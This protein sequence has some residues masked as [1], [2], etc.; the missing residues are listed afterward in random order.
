MTPRLKTTRAARELIKAYEPFHGEAVRRGRR[1]V[2]G[3]GHTAAAK[4]GATVSLQDAELLLIYDVM[5]A[6]QAVHAALGEDLPKPMR[7][8]LV[9][10]A[11]S[12]GVNAFRV[13]DVARLARAGR[14]ED[15]A[16]ALESWV[17]AEEDGKLVVS[18][19]LKQRR[20][21]EKALYL[22][23]FETPAG[24]AAAAIPAPA[25]DP[26]PVDRAAAE[27]SVDEAAEPRLGPLVDVELSFEEPVEPLAAPGAFHGAEA[28]AIVVREAET[29]GADAA[30]I[31]VEPGEE[32]AAD[33]M[34]EAVEA[35]SVDVA[36]EPG[37]ANAFE[38]DADPV[39][40]DAA[41]IAPESVAGEAEPLEAEGGSEGDADP[42]DLAETETQ[43]ETEAEPES[44]DVDAVNAEIAAL[45][46]ANAPD[47]E[48]T[49]FQP[50]PGPAQALEI[51][52]VKAAQD[53]AIAVVMSRMAG[54]MARSVEAAAAEPEA[55]LAGVRLGYHFLECDV[56]GWDFIDQAPEDHA[57]TVEAEVE[58]K[59]EEQTEVET[60][61]VMATAGD[62]VAPEDKPAAV[63]SIMPVQPVAAVA[64]RPA[65]LVP[66]SVYGTVS[67]VPVTVAVVAAPA[68]YAPPHPAEAPAAAPG[69][70]GESEGPD[71]PDDEAAVEP[72]EDEVELEP[73][74]V[75]GPEAVYILEDASDAGADTRGAWVY[76]AGL[77]FGVGLIGFG[78]WE[79]LSNL[80]A[81]LAQGFSY[82]PLG[83]V[84]FGSGVLLAT[85]MGWF[86]LGK[87]R[88]DD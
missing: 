60:E 16:A 65:P 30:D 32:D 22:M 33:A 79:I 76:P 62:P 85:A 10:F 11:A 37:E 56:V 41:N 84:T 81:Y 87:L 73:A 20:L 52:P 5:A 12:V 29:A 55:D 1:W 31:G 46:E 88:E 54:E 27:P 24:A 74:I 82:S 75:A 57:A 36:S 17:R 39:D 35:Q 70:S 8:A 43:T 9:S 83:P 48:P 66:T 13:S 64:V 61:T 15:A 78:A 40:R 72:G 51:D 45:D 49:E 14:H 2:L 86:V 58:A 28:V 63:E 53:A 3:W 68:A 34:A 44:A 21:A 26:A 67:V 77:V 7:D 19:R 6:E 80:D 50:E 18:D 59:L 4:A 38:F 71:H 69:A 23:A 42:V 47:A 25:N